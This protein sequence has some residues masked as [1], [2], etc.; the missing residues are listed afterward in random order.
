V[1]GC[2][3]SLAGNGRLPFARTAVLG[4]LAS[5]AAGCAPLP[6]PDLTTRSAGRDVL[7]AVVTWNVNAGRGDLPQLVTDLT[8]GVLTGKPVRDFIILLQENIEG[9]PHDVQSVARSR[10][11]YTFFT[12]VRLSDRGPSGNAVLSTRPLL[13]ARVIDLPRE[14]RVR[15]AVVVTLE[16]DGIPMFAACTHLEN[17]TSWLKGGLLSDTARGRQARVLLRSLPQG[18]GIVGGDLNTWLGPGE[19]AWRALQERFDETPG[20]AA[21]EPTFRDRLVLDHL[22]FDLPSR[23]EA[24][25][26]VVPERYGSDHHP[27]LGLIVRR[28]GPPFQSLRGQRES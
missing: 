8:T 21:D 4:A 11:L 25:R 22:F 23:W 20:G 2:P 6:P 10:Q 26:A 17:R 15:K 5:L 7:L 14:R 12:E 18:H 13:D 3:A 24:V 16:I 19:P 9:S 1:R 27:V 28:G